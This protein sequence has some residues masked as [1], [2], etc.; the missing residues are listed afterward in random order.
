M[1]RAVAL[2]VEDEP[3]IAE[4][5]ALQLRSLGFDHVLSC[6]T[7]KQAMDALD[8]SSP[9]FAVLDVT[10]GQGKTSG[11]IAERLYGAGIPFAFLTGYP[12]ADPRFGSTPSL[13]KPVT[14]TELDGVLDAAG[15]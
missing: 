4:G 8:S 1:A 15:V 14:M 6:G 12:E 7:E 11:A 9:D 13:C 2:V 5:V 3:I 10:L